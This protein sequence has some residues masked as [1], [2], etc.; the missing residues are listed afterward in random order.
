MARAKLPEGD[1][2]TMLAEVPKWTSV[3]KA[4]ERSWKFRDFKEAMAFLN[5]VAELAEAAN[6]HPDIWNSWNRVKLSLTTHDAGGLTER[7]FKLAKK[8]DAL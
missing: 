1:I 2:R 7:D 8:I 5:R 3:G 6:H 4:I